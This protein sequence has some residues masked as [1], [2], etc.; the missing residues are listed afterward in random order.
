MHKIAQTQTSCKLDQSIVLPIYCG[1]NGAPS[2][3]S[4]IARSPLFTQSSGERMAA[5]IPKTQSFS[6]T[7]AH[8]FGSGTGT[9][10]IAR[11]SAWMM[12]WQKWSRFRSFCKKK[13]SHETMRRKWITKSSYLVIT[14]VAFTRSVGWIVL[15]TQD[16][17]CHL[18][19]GSAGRKK[20]QC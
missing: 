15:N 4:R 8:S 14:Y 3:A 1:G 12:F 20:M 11:S 7:N 10:V 2:R 5:S 16:L 13:D 17:V 6:L 19:K 18:P 9:L